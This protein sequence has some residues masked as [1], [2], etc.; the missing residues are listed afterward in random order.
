MVEVTHRCAVLG[1][2]I[3]HSLSPVIHAV[4]YRELGLAG[5]A[6]GRHEVDEAGLGDFIAGCGPEWVGLSCTMPLKEELLRFGEPTERARLL[7]AGNTYVFGRAGAP[8]LVDNTDVEGILAPIRGAGVERAASAIIVGAGATARSALYALAGLGVR[9]VT[10]VARDAGRARA[11]LGW[12]ASELGVRLEMA[13]WAA[14]D[15]GPCDVLVSVVP[16]AVPAELASGL[17]AGAGLVFDVR[18]GQG[19]SAFA[20]AAAASGVRVLDGLDMLVAQA[21]GQLRLF[22]GREC[23]SGPLMDAARAELARRE[24]R[25]RA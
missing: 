9:E 2:P 7:R 20:A 16:A 5:W 17:V 1:S 21:V 3:A 10:V 13:P 22:T 11:S 23:P 24:V 14:P 8:A 4:A 12:L 25:Q 19:P 18:Y 6:Y 15:V